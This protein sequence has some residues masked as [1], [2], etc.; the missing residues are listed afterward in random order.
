MAKDADPFEMNAAAKQVMAQAYG[1]MDGYFDNLKKTIASAPSGGTEFGEKIKS[2]AEKN[3]TAVQDF[4]R[5]LAQAKDL[6]EMFRIQ[7]EF[8]QGQVTSFG[9]QVK[10]LGEVFTKS[11]TGEIKKSMKIGS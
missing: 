6:E 1:A 8:V 2:Y 5:R 4:V 3:T 7:T 10:S 11:A 9:E